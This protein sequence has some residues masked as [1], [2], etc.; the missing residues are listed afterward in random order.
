MSGGASEDVAQVGVAYSALSQLSRLHT[1]ED[2]RD[3]C[4]PTAELTPFK[5]LTHPS[6]LN[7][8]WV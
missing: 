7:K 3:V 1:P 2:Y 5:D 4:L 6:M 8:R